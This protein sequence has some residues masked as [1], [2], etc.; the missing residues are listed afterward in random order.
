M[1]NSAKNAIT[2]LIITK[3]IIFKDML[4]NIQG[5]FNNWTFFLLQIDKNFRG[6]FCIF[7]S[8]F[9]VVCEFFTKVHRCS[10]KVQLYFFF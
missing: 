2:N 4:S 9:I 10:C 7:L 5:E 3:I 8:S 1:K 6:K